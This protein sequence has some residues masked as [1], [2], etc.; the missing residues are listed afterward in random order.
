MRIAEVLFYDTNKAKVV[1]HMP[2]PRTYS[3]A[4]LPQVPL[5][6]FEAL[7]NLRR[8][9]CY[10]DQGLSFEQ[11]CRS[12]EIPHLLEH[13]IIELQACA[14]GAA[15]LAGETQWNW[16]ID[17]RGTFHVHVEYENEQLVLGCIRLA[18]RILNAALEGNLSDIDMALEIERLRSLAQ[19]GANLRGRED[20]RYPPR[21]LSLV[22]ARTGEKSSEK[23][24]SGAYGGRRRS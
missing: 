13:V 24:T 6:L 17:P 10:N 3:T 11:E 18:E 4:T 23:T 14:T 5:V 2:G 9:T 1:V 19:V 22:A 15:N 20:E 8:H 21:M 7:P 16:R 12:T